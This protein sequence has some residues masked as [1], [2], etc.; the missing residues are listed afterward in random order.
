MTA[1]DFQH[2]FDDVFGS[3]ELIGFQYPLNA[4]QCSR[5]NYCFMGYW[6][7]PTL[8]VKESVQ[9]KYKPM[10]LRPYERPSKVQMRR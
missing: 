2:S 3:P 1:I 4:L 5:K 8:C 6:R 10:A 9:A 7:P